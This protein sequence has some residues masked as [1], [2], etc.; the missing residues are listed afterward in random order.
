MRERRAD[1]PEG[2]RAA[3]VH[4]SSFPDESGE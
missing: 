4:Y 2:A 3:I 1:P